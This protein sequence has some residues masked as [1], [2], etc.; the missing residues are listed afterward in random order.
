MLK[1]A[2]CDDSTVQ[3]EINKF[4]VEEYVKQRGY[5]AIVDTYNHP[6]DLVSNIEKN[7]YHIYILDIIMPMINGIDV[8]KHIR[9]NDK[10]AQII[11]VSTDKSFALDS[12][13]VNPLHYLIKPIK[14]QDF[15]AVM[16]LAISKLDIGGKTFAAKTKEGIINIRQSD[17]ICA[18]YS[19]HKVTFHLIGDEVIT[20]NTISGKFADYVA[21]LLEED[22]FLMCHESYLVNLIHVVSF[23]KP[24]FKTASDLFIPIASRRYAE[25]KTRYNSFSDK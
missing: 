18:E 23:S 10:N 4:F 14:H 1:I 3:L 6:D 25:C 7:C 17:I 24:G 13:S 15:C 19:A 12:F 9:S 22:M 2:I 8:G 5:T 21:P 16:D 11:F 20:T